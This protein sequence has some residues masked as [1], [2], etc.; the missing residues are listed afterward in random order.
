MSLKKTDVDR[1]AWNPDGPTQQLHPDGTV[2]GLFVRVL[3]SGGKRF[4]LRYRPRGSTGNPVSYLVGKYGEI[5]LHQ[6]RD[7]AKGEL[8]K[9]RGGK[10]PQEEKRAVRQ[11][12]TVKAF[13]RVFM[14]R[15]GARK[16]PA[17]IA[18]YQRMLNLH[19]LP[20]IGSKKLNEVKRA[21][22]ARIQAKLA[23][24]PVMANRTIEVV[25]LMF[26][27]AVEW[28]ELS[29]EARNPAI[30]IRPFGEKERDR[31]VTPEEIPRLMASIDS[32]E[33]IYVRAAIR[34]LLLTGCRKNEVLRLQWRD[35]DLKRSEIRLRETKTV[36]RTVPLSAEA[37]GVLEELPRGLGSAWVFPSLI[38]TGQPM[39]NLSKPWGRIRKRAG[40]ED[41]TIHDLRRT[42]GSLM[43][44]SGV[45][46]AIIGK[47][48]G[49]ASPSATKIYARIADE[50][51]RKA[52]DEHGARL[53]ALAGR[54]GAS[55]G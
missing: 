41:V 2:P 27:K 17:T 14:E 48:L 50:A 40:L 30:G 21:D 43:A 34:L 36:A 45:S 55:N 10:D 39:V 28:G 1:L 23:D 18:E 33:N 11:G 29:E 4:V 12:D 49:H 6:A 54:R 8:A 51:A 37:R 35:V 44:T 22:V 25:R 46:P 26:N 20:A 42:A 32:E 16:R 38:K 13:S 3:P 5:T 7:L 19:V 15:H 24:R 31:W 9:V 52:L 47:V 53:G